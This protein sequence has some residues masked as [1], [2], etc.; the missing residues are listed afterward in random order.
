MAV[1]EMQA[2]RTLPSNRNKTTA[3]RMPPSTSECFIFRSAFSMNVAGRCRRGY[4]LTPSFRRPASFR[5]APLPRAM[6]TSMVFAPYWLAMVISTPGRPLM[7]ESPNFGSPRL[8]PR[9]TS[10]SRT[11][12]PLTWATTTSPSTSG[13]SAWPSVW[14]MMRWLHVLDK[15]GAHHAGR[16]TRGARTSEMR[17]SVGQQP[18]G[19]HLD[20]ELPHFAAEDDALAPRPARRAVAA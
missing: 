13:V 2:V 16:N 19:L 15:T 11:L 4:S 12:W 5:P 1:S 6:V 17:Q 20:L 3:T 9:A 14:M 10:L 18:L 7:S 8:R